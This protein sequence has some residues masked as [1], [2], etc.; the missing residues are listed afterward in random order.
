MSLVAGYWPALAGGMLI[1]GATALL[2]LANGRVVGI[3][4]I[5]AYLLD[6]PMPG[7]PGT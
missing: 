1:G 6:G 3:S 4:G 5:K 7:R 2:M